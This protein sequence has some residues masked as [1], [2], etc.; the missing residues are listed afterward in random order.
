MH[1]LQ[2]TEK[3]W[4]RL[5]ELFKEI[6]RVDRWIEIEQK[7]CVVDFKKA[8]QLRQYRRTLSKTAADVC[9]HKGPENV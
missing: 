4:S 6:V 1:L 8:V 3:E 5:P 2:L 9:R 7:T